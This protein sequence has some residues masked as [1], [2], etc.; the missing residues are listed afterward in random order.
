MVCEENKRQIWIQRWSRALRLYRGQTN[1]VPGPESMALRCYT[2][3]INGT[4][5]GGGADGLKPH[6]CIYMWVVPFQGEFTIAL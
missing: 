5:S 3:A 2:V 6:V 4:L 1:A